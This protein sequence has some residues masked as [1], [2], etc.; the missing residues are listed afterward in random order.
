M[1]ERRTPISERSFPSKK[2]EMHSRRS[3]SCF[4]SSGNKSFTIEAGPHPHFAKGCGGCGR[5]SS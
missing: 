5:V 3:S 4:T 2:D 1:V